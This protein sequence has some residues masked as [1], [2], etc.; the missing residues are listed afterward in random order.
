MIDAA[1]KPGIY[2]DMDEDLYHAVRALSASGIKDLLTSPLT[3]WCKSPLNP[4]RRDVDTEARANGK[5]MHIRVL[6]GKEAFARAYAYRPDKADYPEAL[7]GAEALKEKCRELE[8]P[9]GGKIADLCERIAE[10]DPE[11]V[12]WPHVVADFE[13]G[14]EGAILLPP[15]KAWEIEL[16][17][18]VIECHPT[19]A[20]AFTGGYPEVSIFWTDAETGIAMKCRVDYLKVHAAVDLKTFSNPFG[21]PVDKAVVRAISNYKYG[22]QAAVYLD[23][24][25]NAKKLLRSGKAVVEGDVAGGW[26]KDFARSPEHAFVFVFL[27]QGMAPNC[28]VR[29]FRETITG[30]NS[31]ATPNLYWQSAQAGYRIGVETYV[32]YLERFGNAPW[33]DDSPMTPLVDEEFP[34]W[35]LE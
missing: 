25:G 11:V 29:E 12:L 28:R 26:L 7:D 32:R 34:L 20:K 1:P 5:A 18:K 10:A 23:G 13:A 35:A 33:V 14:N 6:A 22:V 27:E 30:A 17:A 19:A 15:D 9:V 16:P 31:G 4:N 21:I 2:F 24:I 3:Y 8:L